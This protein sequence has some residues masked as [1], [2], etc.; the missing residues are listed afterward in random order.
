MSGRYVI[1]P[2]LCLLFVGSVAYVV[3]HRLYS[4]D[5]N[6]I[7]QRQQHTVI[8][9]LK[10]GKF[11][12]FDPA[13]TPNAISQRVHTLAAT[14]LSKDQLSALS[15]II[16][17]FFRCYSQTNFAD[18]LI[19]KSLQ[20]D[21]EWTVPHAENVSDPQR[22][23]ERRW[24]ARARAI[25]YRLT[26]GPPTPPMRLTKFDVA[27]LTVDVRPLFST[28]APARALQEAYTGICISRGAFTKYSIAPAD[29]LNTPGAK[30]LWATWIFP[31]VALSMGGPTEPGPVAVSAFWDDSKSKWI[32]DTCVSAIPPNFI[33]IL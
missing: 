3:R 31:C 27:H 11:I 1:V 6:V 13:S 9:N 22:E 21:F 15:E 30:I 19:F 24:A 20:G 25:E 33:P 2:F 5:I 16:A 7:Q 17:E 28:N 29:L 23:A 18:Y 14:N 8:Q 12:T 26:N 32:V 4:T 10:G